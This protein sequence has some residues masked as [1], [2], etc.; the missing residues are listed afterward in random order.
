M[1]LRITFQSIWRVLLQSV[2]AL[3]VGN[4]WNKCLIS[5]VLRHMWRNIRLMILCLPLPLDLDLDRTLS[6]SQSWSYCHLNHRLD[7][8]LTAW[9]NCAMRLVASIMK[10]TWIHFMMEN[11]CSIWRDRLSMMIWCGHG[12]LQLINNSIH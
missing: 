5:T 1:I 11:W 7:W 10:R 9:I 2:F 6:K 3:S 8:R 12:D 4:C